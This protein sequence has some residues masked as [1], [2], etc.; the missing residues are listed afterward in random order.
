M[1]RKEFEKR[2]KKINSN[3]CIITDCQLKPVGI[4][5][6]D[7]TG[8][9]TRTVFDLMKGIWHEGDNYLSLTEHDELRNLLRDSC[10]FLKGT[11][12]FGDS[13]L[14]DLTPDNLFKDY[15]DHLAKTLQEKNTA[16]G[17]SFTESVKKFG[18][19]V[20]PIRLSDKFNRVCELTKRGELKENDESLEDTLLDLAGYSILGLK[21]LKEH[22]NK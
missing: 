10:A 13:D 2:L 19:T 22:E 15:T 16:Y 11:H 21:Y 17:D 14:K 7:D 3:L 5:L 4:L 8:N 20:I 12:L 6:T 9:A 18:L 1:T